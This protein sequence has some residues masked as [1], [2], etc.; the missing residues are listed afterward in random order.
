M[1]KSKVAQKLSKKPIL[2]R[3]VLSGCGACGES[4]SWA[5]ERR[6]FQK[7]WNECDRGDWM[8][9]ILMTFALEGSKKT[10]KELV[11]VLTG[12]F[13]KFVKLSC[14]RATIQ[15]DPKGAYLLNGSLTA[16]SVMNAGVKGKGL[17][18]FGK[19]IP[20]NLVKMLPGQLG[21]PAY[22]LSWGVYHLIQ[23]H[24][25]GLSSYRSYC[26]GDSFLTFYVEST[27]CEFTQAAKVLADLIREAVPNAPEIP[28]AIIREVKEARI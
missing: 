10:S 9:W 23:L 13:V 17:L 19:H 22:A 16:L 4:I 5:G 1:T 11:K 3:E 26:A 25:D 2:L 27:R 14:D 28:S 24:I 6:N 21:G 18:F 8:L 20:D 7:A 15:L 12:I